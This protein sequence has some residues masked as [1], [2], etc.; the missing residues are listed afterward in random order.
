MGTAL[1]WHDHKQQAR[2]RGP[3]AVTT[4]V[5]KEEA[6]GR[7]RERLRINLGG[8][9]G[10]E[11]GACFQSLES[12]LP[13]RES[14]CFLRPPC[15]TPSLAIFLSLLILLTYLASP[16]S[17]SS[18]LQLQPTNLRRYRRRITVGGRTSDVWKLWGWDTRFFVEACPTPILTTE[19]WT[20]ICKRVNRAHRVTWF[21][22]LSFC[23]DMQFQCQIC[24]FF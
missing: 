10:K 19:T 1:P 8:K 7:K 14:L 17:L 20:S 6:K 23:D 18:S 15:L 11:R 9:F 24:I 4:T 13:C 21:V 16:P 5:H 2:I 3:V 22:F 12:R